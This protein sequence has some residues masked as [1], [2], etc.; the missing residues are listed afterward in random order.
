[1]NALYGYCSITR[2]FLHD[3]S[4]V[5]ATVDTLLKISSN[6][7]SGQQFSSAHSAVEHARMSA[8][9]SDLL[10]DL[11]ATLNKDVAQIMKDS[12]LVLASLSDLHQF[13]DSRAA[14]ELPKKKNKLFMV[15][16][17]I[18]F[19]LSYVHEYGI[20]L[21]ILLWMNEYN[22]FSACNSLIFHRFYLECV[23]NE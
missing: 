8:L 12:R 14:A 10:P 7:S 4:D 17:K 21:P 16:K 20:E 6:L 15:V 19:Y 13:L 23:N 11:C 18:E 3:W 1:M 22:L 2:L 9:A 5:K